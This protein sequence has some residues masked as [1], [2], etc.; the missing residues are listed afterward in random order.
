MQAERCRLLVGPA[1]PRTR[2]TDDSDADSDAETEQP[3]IPPEL[4]EA[5]VAV[6]IEGNFMFNKAEHMDFMGSIMNTGILRPD[7]SACTRAR[8]HTHTQGLPCL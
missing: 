6:V 7:V 4:K 1:D 2:K 8:T 5:V 3:A